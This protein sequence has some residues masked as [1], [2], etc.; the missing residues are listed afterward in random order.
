MTDSEMMKVFN[1]L[2]SEDMSDVEMAISVLVAVE[3]A[4]EE[5]ISKSK[6]IFSE[7]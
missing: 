1:S 6:V 4:K 5:E 3:M 2:A 7:R